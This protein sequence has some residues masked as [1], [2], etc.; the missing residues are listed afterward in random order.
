MSDTSAL[1][2]GSDVASALAVRRLSVRLGGSQILQD[3][4]LQVA[5]G[6]TLV[7]L[8]QSG[9]GKTTLLKAIA[10][11]VSVEHGEV[12]LDGKDITAAA[13]RDRSII[14]LDQE[15]LLFEHL[16]VFENVAFSMRMKGGSDSD[17]YEAVSELL[18]ATGLSV[19]ALKRQ[20]QLSGGQKQRVAFARAILAR[21]RLLLL[22]EPFAS[23]D[24]QTRCQMQDLFAVLRRQHQLTSIFVTHDVREALTV[25]Q[26]FAAMTPELQ[27]FADRETFVQSPATGVLG[28]LAFWESVAKA[29]KRPGES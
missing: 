29:A 10:G 12:H 11:L 25:G 20:H 8:G 4:S 1:R 22:D 26:S 21:P 18:V 5:A 16:N 13:I 15:P 19:L 7:V 14:Y 23:L 27:L 6:S 9:C 17:I 2:D 28:E 24:S 3:V